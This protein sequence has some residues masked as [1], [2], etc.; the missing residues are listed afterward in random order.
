MRF[1]CFKYFYKLKMFLSSV[2]FKGTRPLM[3]TLSLKSKCSLRAAAFHI[4]CLLKTHT[5]NKNPAMYETENDPRLRA[6]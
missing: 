4:F 5:K 2:F 3:Y 1:N 6:G